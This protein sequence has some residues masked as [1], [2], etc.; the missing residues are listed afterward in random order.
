[1]EPNINTFRLLGNAKT[2]DHSLPCPLSGMCCAFGC[3]SR[4][5]ARAGGI[6]DGLL[7]GPNAALSLRTCCD[8]MEKMETV[9]SDNEDVVYSIEEV[10]FQLED[11]ADCAADS[12]KGESP[13]SS[14]FEM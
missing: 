6:C 2:Y 7:K 12:A 11:S 4:P 14:D 13:L 10:R 3:F 9:E 5:S 1:M 8:K